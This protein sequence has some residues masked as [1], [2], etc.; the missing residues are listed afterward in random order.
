MTDPVSTLKAIGIR[1]PIW[2]MEPPEIGLTRSGRREWRYGGKF[3]AT[4]ALIPIAH[5]IT[6][7]WDVIIDRAPSGLT[8]RFNREEQE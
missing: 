3:L 7:G 1:P 2:A 5:L 4:S 8:I 6:E